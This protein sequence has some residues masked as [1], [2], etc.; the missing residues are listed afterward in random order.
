MGFGRG[1]LLWLLGIPL[2]IVLLLA[3]FITDEQKRWTISDRRESARCALGLATIL[4]FEYAAQTGH[5]CVL[6]YFTVIV[7]KRIRRAAARPGPF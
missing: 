6:Q 4:E 7:S 5:R 3:L 1:A 2:P